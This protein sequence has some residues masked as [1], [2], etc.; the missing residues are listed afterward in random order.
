MEEECSQLQ[1]AAS[2]PS[3]IGE[4]ENWSLTVFLSNFV[5]RTVQYHKVQLLLPDCV[6]R[7]AF[8]KGILFIQRHQQQIVVFQLLLPDHVIRKAFLKGIL[9]IQRHRQ[10]IVD[11]QLLD[12]FLHGACGAGGGGRSLERMARADGMEMRLCSTKNTQKVPLVEEASN[13][14]Q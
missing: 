4:V 7:K 13:G 9:F 10:Q 2:E 6:I 1:Q 14:H 8:L 3:G 5:E 12:I 11:F